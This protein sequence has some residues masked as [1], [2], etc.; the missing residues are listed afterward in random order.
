MTQA[1]VDTFKIIK[2]EINLQSVIAVV[3]RYPEGI[4]QRQV[5]EVI[6]RGRPLMATEIGAL[7][8]LVSRNLSLAAKEG[9]LDDSESIRVGRG[10]RTL[11]RVP[12]Q[13]LPPRKTKTQ[14][15]REENLRLQLI[16]Q[17][18]REDQEKQLLN[19][20]ATAVELESLSRSLN[21]I[22]FNT[23]YDG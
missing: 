17:Q 11:Y 12:A 15:L 18:M 7:Y 8:Q 16:I 21:T 22:N 1:Q 14:K 10:R 4:T 23:A 3:D 6:Y 13:P 9:F 5:F 19:L 2:D 20:K